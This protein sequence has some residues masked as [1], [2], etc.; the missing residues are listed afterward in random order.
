MNGTINPSFMRNMNNLITKK[1]SNSLLKK[2][3][4]T[5]GDH[6]VV[7]QARDKALLK[8]QNQG[9]PGYTSKNV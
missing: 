6:R 1:A 7:G 9:Y 8:D 2:L 4:A 3:E 5:Q